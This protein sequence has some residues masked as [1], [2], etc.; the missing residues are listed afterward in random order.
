MA[1]I[2][3]RYGLFDFD[4]VAD[5]YDRW[6]ESARG[7]MYDRLEKKAL[8]RWLGAGGGGKR[9][10]EVGCGSGHWS[11][12]FSEKGFEVT[13]VDLSEKMIRLARS[14]DIRGSVLQVADG[15]NLPFPDD[16]FAVAA[17]ITTLEFTANPAKV[18]SEMTR[19]VKKPGGRLL[20]GVL[21][22]LS[23]Y[24]R[25]R[26]NKA[27]SVYASARLFTPAQLKD[28]LRTFGE[29]EIM[30][31]GFIPRWD[32][33]IP[34]SPLIDYFAQLASNNRGAFIAAEVRL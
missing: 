15:E 14:K 11:E 5:D 9:L 6:Y 18:M 1:D 25:R 19:C 4:R 28:L 12:Y 17:A 10:L 21:N 32:W 3:K 29:V 27:A 7:A 8:D 22:G 13:G 31:A 33:L 30:I 16:S 26:T 2:Q 23:G 20:V 34:V 24:N